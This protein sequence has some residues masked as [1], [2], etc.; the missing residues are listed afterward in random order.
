MPQNRQS[1]SV[2]L[3]I[4]TD[5]EPAIVT[6]VPEKQDGPVHAVETRP[7]T[8]A[9]PL[10]AILLPSGH[11][12]GTVPEVGDRVLVLNVADGVPLVLSALQDEGRPEDAATLRA[13]E[14]Q[15]GHTAS[16]AHITLT[17]GGSVE[18][19]A[20]NGATIEVQ[21]DGTISINGGSDPVVTDVSASTTTDAD[22]H[23]TDVDVDVTTDDSVLL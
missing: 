7:T 16:D 21:T 19:T 9:E 1:A 2:G 18:I 4:G 15:I 3:D 22:G 23:V 11:N 5:V 8:S 6:N 14:R 20:N 10:S 12:S 13:G 17:P